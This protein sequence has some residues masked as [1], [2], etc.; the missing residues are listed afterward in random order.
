VCGNA[1][2]DGISPKGKREGV[3]KGDFL[4]KRRII[5]ASGTELVEY[6]M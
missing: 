6:L 5:V 2:R 1:F 3:V 4:S